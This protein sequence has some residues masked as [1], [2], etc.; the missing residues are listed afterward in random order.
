MAGVLEYEEKYPNIVRPIKTFGG[1]PDP[2]KYLRDPIAAAFSSDGTL[3]V[4]DSGNRRVVEL[5]L[6][7][8][9]LQTFGDESIDR[10]IINPTAIAQDG[11]DI[12]VADGGANS[13]LIFSNKGRLKQRWD[14]FGSAPKQFRDPRGISVSKTRVAVADTGNN[15]IQIFDKKGNLE[16]I[17]DRGD[18]DVPFN[19]PSGVS[20]DDRDGVWIA[21]TH[22][23]RISRYDFS[24]KRFTKSVGVYGSYPGQFAEP[25]SIAWQKGEI[26]VTDLVNHRVQIFSDTGD[27]KYTFARHPTYPREGNGRVHYPM[28]IAVDRQGALVAIC[29]SFENRVQVFSTVAVKTNYRAVTDSAWWEKYPNFHYGRR[30]KMAMAKD[31]SIPWPGDVLT[32]SEPDNHKVIMFDVSGDRPYKLAEFG[33]LGENLGQLKGPHGV[34]VNH[35]GE[36]FVTDSFNHRVVVLD[37]SSLKASADMQRQ[38]RN[39]TLAHISNAVDMNRA[40]QPFTPRV[41]RAF[42]KRGNGPGEFNTP[43]SGSAPMASSLGLGDTV[44]IGDTRN[45]RIQIYNHDGTFTDKIIGGYGTEPGKLNLPTDLTVDP[46]YGL[47]YV[48]EAF[49]RRVSAFDVRTNAFLFVVGEPGVDPGQFMAPSA[50]AVDSEGNLYVTDQGTHRVSV[51]TPI[52]EDGHIVGSKYSTSWG[53]YGVEP[54]DML[55]PQGITIDS[56]DRIY[57]VDFGNHRGEM[58]TREG[59]FIDKFGEEVLQSKDSEPSDGVTQE[60]NFMSFTGVDNRNDIVSN[61]GTYIVHIPDLNKLPVGEVQ[62][63]NFQL[64]TKDGSSFGDVSVAVKARMEQHNHGMDVNPQVSRVSDKTFQVDGFYLQMAGDWTIYI[65]ITRGGVT[66][67]AQG[68]FTVGRK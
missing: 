55:Y 9:I 41:I 57:I 18:G 1:Y 4:A 8:H 56:K 29:E 53:K 66:E 43:S 46:K 30:L 17:I 10:K 62:S 35:L 21:D 12:Y 16:T 23:N 14:G 48:V 38:F 44:F 52:I 40:L 34:G 26:Y 11:D 51:F 25:T 20:F 24:L 45:H 7:G 58:F 27:F 19:E 65:D 37:L 6:E 33:E 5:D 42:G 3:L 67:R 61:A 50:A 54:G 47:L 60:L 32:M 63:I 2:G 59:Q 68:N 28:G 13:I 64:A 36:M 39:S 15:R 22:N 31:M 49:N